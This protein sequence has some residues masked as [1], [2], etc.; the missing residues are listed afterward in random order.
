MKNMSATDI[1]LI[2]TCVFTGLCSVI[3]AVKSNNASKNTSDSQG[4]INTI[5]KLTNGNLA[6]AKAKLERVEQERDKLQRLVQ[7][8]ANAAPP[9]SLAEIKT[10]ADDHRADDK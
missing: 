6:E 4:T 10:R 7:E 3:A 1:V 8:L 2:L 5:H 9:G